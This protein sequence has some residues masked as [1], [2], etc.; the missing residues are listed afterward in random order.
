V[1]LEEQQVQQAV[2]QLIIK[3][4]QAVLVQLLLVVQEA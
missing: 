3:V 4:W 2:V 1:A